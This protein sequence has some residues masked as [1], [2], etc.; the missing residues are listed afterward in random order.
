MVRPLKSRTMTLS[1]LQLAT[2]G[3]I[4]KM[5]K[6]LSHQGYE[7]GMSDSEFIENVLTPLEHTIRADRDVLRRAAKAGGGDG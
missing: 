2:L 5:E 1:Q 6:Q 7:G 4:R 3:L